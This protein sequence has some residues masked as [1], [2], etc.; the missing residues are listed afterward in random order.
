M[1]PD[2]PAG[3]PPPASSKLPAAPSRR[4]A[5]RPSEHPEPGSVREQR[6]EIDKLAAVAHAGQPTH[7]G[8]PDSKGLVSFACPGCGRLVWIK[9]KD[10]GMQITCDGCSQ[11]I[12]CP[13]SEEPA[14][15]LNPG[16]IQK[17]A[18]PKA[19]LPQKRSGDHL[20]LEEFPL[21]EAET[22]DLRSRR[23]LLPGSPK[24]SQSPATPA[25]K[26]K[27]VVKP[28]PKSR[29]VEI[30]PSEL[31]RYRSGGK[32]GKKSGRVQ[33]RKSQQADLN[34]GAFLRGG[35]EAE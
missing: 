11:D 30:S 19:V 28:I 20:P 34:E 8:T 27:S 26:R 4:F 18:M 32:K 17:P 29:D 6:K 13:S 5:T 9:P 25:P 35:A 14:R 33:S 15:L 7:L 24:K 16:G 21:T 1:M 10:A 3:S 22:K 12:V 31:K 23:T 2:T